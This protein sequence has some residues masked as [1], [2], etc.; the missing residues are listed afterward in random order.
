MG[1]LK[2]FIW[3]KVRFLIDFYFQ[4]KLIKIPL[5]QEI[6]K[7]RREFS[8]WGGDTM[9]YSKFY[10]L[11]REIRK[12]K[13][14]SVLEFGSGVSTLIIGHALKENRQGKLISM[15]ENKAYGERVMSIIGNSYPIE[16]HVEDLIDDVYRDVKGTRYRNIPDEK[17]G[18]IFVDGP[19]TKTVD[20]DTFYILDKCP[21][22]KVMIDNRKNTFRALKN[23]YKGFFFPFINIGYIN[24]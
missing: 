1:K 14:I 22:A 19:T 6:V 9:Y 13:P 16:M 17:Y 12:Q 10:I 21:N 18:F 23:K 2:K 11:Y 4:K 7:F 8:S 5:W 15:E 20:L 3:R 24:Y